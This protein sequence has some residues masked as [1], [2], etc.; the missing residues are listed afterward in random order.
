MKHT[1]KMTALCLSTLGL[2][3]LAFAAPA[4]QQADDEPVQ[5]IE[6]AQQIDIMRLVLAKSINRGFTDLIAERRTPEDRAAAQE[7]A[8]IAQRAGDYVAALGAL[9]AGHQ[10]TQFTSHTRGF[11]AE[12]IGVVFSSEVKTP[13]SEV[14]GYAAEKATPEPD[15]W[16]EATDEVRGGAGGSSRRASIYWDAVTNAQAVDS[17]DLVLWAIDPEFVE[18]VIG[19]VL[20]MLGKHGLKIEALPGDEG[21]VVGLKLEP[22]RPSSSYIVGGSEEPAAELAYLWA[23][24]LQHSGARRAAP[25]HLVI[26]ISK[27]SLERL[28]AGDEVDVAALRR[29]ARITMYGGEPVSGH[30]GSSGMR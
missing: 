2:A 24:R 7:A 9:R 17:D 1:K 28:G 30:R 25:K 6:L 29:E 13:V 11:Y 26:Q 3:A 8:V 23:N 22:H 19:S 20:T 27:R 21:I 5:M 16:T 4:P 15:E 18:A 14:E 10:K 12:G